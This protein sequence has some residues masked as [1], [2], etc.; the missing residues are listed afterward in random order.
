M[1]GSEDVKV[2]KNA[3]KKA[4]KAE[5]RNKAKAEKDAKR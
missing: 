4:A 3:A 2:S 5:A 1:E